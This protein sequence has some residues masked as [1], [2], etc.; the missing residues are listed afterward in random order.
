MLA[1]PYTFMLAF[2]I[3][4]AF[5]T[6]PSLTM[7]LCDEGT[8][9][10][11]YVHVCACVSSN[12][13][14]DPFFFVFALYTFIVV[15]YNKVAAASGTRAIYFWIRNKFL[16]SK[17]ESRASYDFCFFFPILMHSIIRARR[18]S[19]Y[20]SLLCEKKKW[21]MF[22]EKT[23]SICASDSKVDEI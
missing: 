7:S 12:R 10:R 3:C 19:D 5:Q 4:H 6:F 11:T 18:E 1:I 23:I 2:A 8:Y 17:K 20:S 21:L 13:F 16:Y 15:P 9:V 14:S 22:R